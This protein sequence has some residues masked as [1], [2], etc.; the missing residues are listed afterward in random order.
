MA[1]PGTATAAV[2][3]RRDTRREAHKIVRI[4][5]QHGACP[6]PVG[7][8]EGDRPTAAGTQ[9]EI[10]IAVTG[11]V[12]SL[13]TQAEAVTVP[14]GKELLHPAGGGHLANLLAAAVGPALLLQVSDQVRRWR[15]VKVVRAAVVSSLVAVGVH[16]DDLGI[17][18][19][20]F[21]DR[22]VMVARAGAIGGQRRY[23][24]RGGCRPTGVDAGRAA[25]GRPDN[26]YIE[27]GDNCTGR[28]DRTTAQT[29]GGGEE[30]R[31]H[32]IDQ[33]VR[34]GIGNAAGLI[35]RPG[36]YIQRATIGVG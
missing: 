20:G 18:G 8:K 2:E 17:E 21:G 5:G 19:T 27:C 13:P 30:R 14:A 34:R 10:E 7:V 31:R 3:R 26:A 4:E 23:G 35:G 22:L 33:Y 6:A 28:D 11:E 29:D 32:H 15:T 25:N 24:S 12:E 9:I 16:G 36:G 1:V